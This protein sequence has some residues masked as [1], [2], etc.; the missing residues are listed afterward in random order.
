MTDGPSTPT[1]AEV[2]A[3]QARLAALAA[4]RP[5]RRRRHPAQGAR[6]AAAG[7]GATTLLGL[8]GAMAL[9]RP[10]GSAATPAPST[11]APRVVVV[12]HRPGVPDAVAP[13]VAPQAGDRAATPLT[14]RP[15][16]RPAAPAART[17]AASTSGSH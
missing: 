4:D 8:V 14:A 16:V 9:D 11:A 17:P 5:A 6:I 13:S 15:T 10:A 7:L 12:V 3:R 1:P 2:A